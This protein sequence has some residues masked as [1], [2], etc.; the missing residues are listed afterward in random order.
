[1]P[2]NPTY[3]GVYVEELES[4]VHPIVG[5]QTAMT[6]FVG[7]AKTGPRDKAITI[8]SFEEYVSIFGGLSKDSSMSYAVY[9]YFLNGGAD[10]IIVA[11]DDNAKPDNLIRKFTLTGATAGAS[12]GL[13]FESLNVGKVNKSFSVL[14]E[15]NRD[16]P[17]LVNLHVKKYYDKSSINLADWLKG[18]STLESFY[19]L[20]LPDTSLHSI[21]QVL[22]DSSKYINVKEGSLL[23]S[24][25]TSAKSVGIYQA[26]ENGAE[27]TPATTTTNEWKRIIPTDTADIEAKKGIYALDDVDIFNIL[28]IPPLQQNDGKNKVELDVSSGGVYSS[29]LKYCKDRRAILIVDPP[30]SWDTKSKPLH[31][32]TGIDGGT[33]GSLRDE[34]AAIFFPRILAPDPLDGYALREFVP[35]GFVAGVMARTDVDRGVWKAPAGIQAGIAGA[36]GVTVKLTDAENGELNPLGINCLRIKPPAGIVVWGSRTMRG[37]DEL[38]NQWKYLPVRRLALYIEESLYRGT[39][40]VVFEP[41][42]ERLWAQIRLNVG[43]F[44]Q[45]LFN[46]G[47]FQGITPK[48]AYLVKCDHDTTT[49]LDIDRGTVNILVGFAPLKPAEFVI[50]QIKQLAGQQNMLEAKA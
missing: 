27:G 41:N 6:A 9:Q 29:A 23:D 5:V 38:A 13:H 3:P 12:D 4:S 44:M 1:M 25:T 20:A 30:K 7:R 28:C 34:N 35:C 46:K 26:E 15:A 21:R 49:Q 17:D 32:T 22:N 8:H 40:W 33:F 42:D 37:A 39:Q 18:S 14:V 48:E 11:I 10:A 45:D 31:A 43:S 19:R 50:L 16:A 2:I 36:S 47:A 24:T